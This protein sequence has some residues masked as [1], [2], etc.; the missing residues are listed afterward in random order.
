MHIY[1]YMTKISFL[2]LVPSAFRQN[3]CRRKKWEKSNTHAQEK[4][5]VT[6]HLSHS[7]SVPKLAGQETKMAIKKDDSNKCEAIHALDV[8]LSRYIFIAAF[9]FQ[10]MACKRFA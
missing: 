7:F 2:F 1:L 10:M 5:E 6:I 8:E 9:S 3:I 4:K